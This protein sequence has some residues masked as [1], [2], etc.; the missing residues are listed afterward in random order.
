MIPFV[1]LR[2]QYKDIEDNVKKRLHKVL[3]HGQ[4]ILGP[5][6]EELETKLAKFTGSDFCVGVSSGTDALL[7]ALVALDVGPGD[8]VIVPNFS[9]FAT[10]EVVAILGAKPIFVDVNRDDFL[11]DWKEVVKNISSKTKAIIA[12]SLYGQCPDFDQIEK[13]IDGKNISIIEDGAQSFG[14]SYKGKKSCSISTISCTSFFPSKPLGCYGD[15]GACFTNNKKI[16]TT[17]K[18]LRVHGQSKKYYHGRIGING[19]LDTIQAAVLL[20][21]LEIFDEEI[22]LR[23][24]IAKKYSEELHFLVK[25]QKIH[26]YNTTVFAQYTI[27]IEERDKFLNFM[28]DQ[29][30]PTTIHY[31]LPLSKQPALSKYA[32]N[33]TENSEYLTQRVISL[34]ISPYLKKEHQERVIESIKKFK[35]TTGKMQSC[36]KFFENSKL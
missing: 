28:K 1:D 12:V 29:K 11:I 9:F 18:E 15:G 19:R 4:Y 20:E 10:A 8:E 22:K 5:E 30:I 24:N 27:L 23:N 33:L 3:E 21:K 25:T 35:K 17:L 31:P 26:E 14:S 32:Q 16:A 36:N 34:P 13:A 2:S 7:M 6:V